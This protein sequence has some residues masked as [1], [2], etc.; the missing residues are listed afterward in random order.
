MS[1]MKQVLKVMPILR[2]I[3]NPSQLRVAADC[4][5]GEDREFFKSKLVELA[6]IFK[7]MPKT[8]ETDG[9]GK[10]A[11]VSLHYFVS[12]CDWWIV[13]KD[14]DPDD[15]GQLQVFGYADLGYGAE[16]GYISIP[17]ILENGGE[18]D[19]HWTPKTVQDVLKDQK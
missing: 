15:A 11:I 6:E 19:F 1:S 13:E 7:T 9:Q 3:V 12:G 5:R 10:K 16:A 14:S 17:E 2:Q 4:C 18:L 8:Y